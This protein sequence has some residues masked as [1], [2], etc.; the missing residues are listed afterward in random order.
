MRHLFT[1]KA[2]D[3]HPHGLRRLELLI[4]LVLAVCA[5]TVLGA[6]AGSRIA[7]T[8]EPLPDRPEVLAIARTVWDE[9]EPDESWVAESTRAELYASQI[10][11]ED[12]MGIPGWAQVLFGD[13]TMDNATGVSWPDPPGWVESTGEPYLYPEKPEDN[14]RRLDE[15]AARLTASGWDVSRP[16]DSMVVARRGTLV[17]DFWASGDGHTP[18]LT[19]YRV[20]PPS[21]PWFA[22]FGALLGACA[23]IAAMTAFARHRRRHPPIG[24][25]RLGFAG[26]ALLGVNFAIAVTVVSFQLHATGHLDNPLWRSARFIPFG[27]TMNLGLAALAVSVFALVRQRRRAGRAARPRS[28]GDLM[29]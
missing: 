28:P 25:N 16:F 9:R 20:P 8:D 1:E 12:V 15:A 24:G 10:E 18:D 4:A 22:G 3:P 23:G 7:G 19:L 2:T 27:F 11:H 14:A 13:A 5:G 29:G 17:L 21:H 26:L 6:M